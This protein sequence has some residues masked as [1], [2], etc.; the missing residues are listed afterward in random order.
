[1]RTALSARDEL[2][3]A[4]W[5]ERP[6]P[7]AAESLDTYVYRLRRLLGHDR[8]SRASGGYVLRVEPG[9]L[10]VDEFEALVATIA[11]RPGARAL[12]WTS[13]GRHGRPASGPCRGPATGG[14]AAGRLEVRIEAQLAGGDGPELVPELEWLVSVHPLHERLLASLMLALYRAGRQ[15]DA[16]DAFR[17][18]RRR[19]VDELGLEPGPQLHELQQRILEHD[20]TLTPRRAPAPV[21]AVRRHRAI[22]VAAALVVA[23][24]IGG[25]VLRAGATDQPPRLAAGD[26]GVV[27]L[28][29]E[30]GRVATA[31]T[32]GGHRRR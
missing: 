9:E 18:A 5:P 7:S 26:S 21:R 30:S 8:L 15:T 10:D 6:P 24:G 25:L 16:L 1:M 4:L 20:P 27:A 31:T 23:A 22:A 29:T 12:A 3:D 2:L 32:L 13:M 28:N 19:L 11:A 17:S 14:V